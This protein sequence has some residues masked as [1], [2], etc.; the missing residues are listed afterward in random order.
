M[1]IRLFTIPNFIT[2][3]NLLCGCAAVVAALRYGDPTTAFLLLVA[4]AV[5]DFFD[6]FAARLLKSYSPLGVQLDSLADMVSFGLAPASILF[7]LASQSRPEVGV[8]AFAAY[9]LAAFSALRLAK[10]NIDETQ[11][12]EFCGLPTPAAALFAAALGLLRDRGELLLPGWA[13]V[14]AAVVLAL[15]LVSP[16]RMFALKFHGFGWRGNELRY[17]FILFSAVLLALL[18]WFAVPVIILSYIVV[19]TVRWLVA[20]RRERA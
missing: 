6:G 7:T 12:S 10:F 5:C 8:W 20:L 15:L 18:Q 19:S 13:Y 11:T 16:V 1:K 14:A 9:L 17:G 4:A 2:L 3:A